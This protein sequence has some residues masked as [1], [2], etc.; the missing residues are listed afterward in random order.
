MSYSGSTLN[1][2]RAIDDV[3]DWET[4][5]HA[6]MA[7]KHSGVLHTIAESGQIDD[8]TAEHLTAAIK[9]YAASR[10]SPDSEVGPWQAPE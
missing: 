8:D 9:E 10:G 3:A 1:E 2:T 7:D 4:G 6:F 5:Y